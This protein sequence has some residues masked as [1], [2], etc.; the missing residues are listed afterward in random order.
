MSFE[1]SAE[2]LNPISLPHCSRSAIAAHSVQAE[3]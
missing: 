1:E 2:L 3:A